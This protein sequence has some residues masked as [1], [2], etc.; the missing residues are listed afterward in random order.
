MIPERY[1]LGNLVGAIKNQVKSKK[2]FN[3]WF[4]TTEYHIISI[5]IGGS[6]NQNTE[7]E[8]M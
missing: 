6:S 5:L 3:I 4:L 1:N 8:S 2:K 7:K